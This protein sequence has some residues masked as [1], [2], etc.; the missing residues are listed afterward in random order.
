MIGRVFSVCL[1]L[2]RAYDNKKRGDYRHPSRAYR[3][4]HCPY[5][6]TSN[7][8]APRRCA[9]YSLFTQQGQCTR[10]QSAVMP[11]C[12]GRNNHIIEDIYLLP[13]LWLQ[14]RICEIH[15]RQR[16]NVGKRLSIM[17]VPSWWPLSANRSVVSLRRHCKNTKKVL[18]N[19]WKTKIFR[20][21]RYASSG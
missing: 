21:K 1:V 19:W 10:R 14:V 4:S 2:C 8:R 13:R 3:L 17:Y 20:C 16:Q 11:K 9:I 5:S 18:N 6:R 15:I 7:C 12:K